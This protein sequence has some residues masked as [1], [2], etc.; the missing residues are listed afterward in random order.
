MQGS[1]NQQEEAAQTLEGQDGVQQAESVPSR[2]TQLLAKVPN[3]SLLATAFFAATPIINGTDV[4]G[5]RH[6]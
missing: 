3:L 6:G 4:L 5:V 2:M 1:Q